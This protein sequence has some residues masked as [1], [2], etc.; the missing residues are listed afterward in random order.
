[1]EAVSILQKAVALKS[2]SAEAWIN[3]GEALSKKG[4][5]RA[6]ADAHRRAATLRPAWTEAWLRLGLALDDGGDANGA[7]EAYRRALDLDPRSFMAAYNLGGA[8]MSVGRSAE[9]VAAYET[10]LRVDPNHANAHNNLGNALRRQRRYPDAI[11]AYQR[12]AALD[13]SFTEALSNAAE[14]LHLQAEENAAVDTYR[15]V[16]RGNPRHFRAR[17]AELLMLPTLYDSETDIDRWR[18]RW[19]DGLTALAEEVRQIPPE[20]W[21]GVVDAAT[22]LTNFFLHYQCQDDT[23]LQRRYG[24]VISYI[25]TRTCPGV[26]VSMKRSAKNGERIRVGFASALLYDH[27]VAKLFGGWIEELDADRF[28]PIILHLG[29]QRDR[30]T[31]RLSQRG[32]LV[33]LGSLPIERQAE[34][35]AS[36]DLDALVFLDVGM[37]GYAQF[38]AALKLAPVQCVTFG[39]PV[40]SGLASVDYFLSSALAEPDDGQRYYT[41]RLIRLPNLGFCYRRPDIASARPPSARREEGRLV[42]LN[43]QS[44]VKFLP[45]YDVLYPRIAKRVPNACFWFIRDGF[46]GTAVKFHARLGRA[47]AAHDLDV[48]RHCVMFPAMPHGEFLGLNSAADV[49]LDTISWSGG[50]TVLEAMAMG[51]PAVTMRSPMLRGRVAAAI[52]ERAGIVDTVAEDLDAYVDIAVRLAT[53]SAWRRDVY[54]RAAAGAEKLWDDRAAVE[55]LEIFLSKAV[56]GSAGDPPK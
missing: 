34:A 50:N 44:T 16:Y 9:A 20:A 13:P 37:H 46:P 32:N 15:A 47:F 43:T 33:V 21:P 18:E 14:L 25:A 35:I 6:S 39:H 42:F 48:D 53:E 23:D 27:T 7:A 3:L 30:M 11:A 17:W 54:E 28:E 49:V 55:G 38:L 19:S 10:A 29:A 51:R 5:F 4:D 41:E 40:T 1:M 45:Q 36:H 26:A 31:E 12:A 8:L 24:K 56:A 22:M 2:D 52:L